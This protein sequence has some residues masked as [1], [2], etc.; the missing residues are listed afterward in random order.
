[1]KRERLWWVRLGWIP[2]ASAAIVLLHGLSLAQIP[3]AVGSESGPGQV[4][5]GTSG[6]VP[7]TLRD[8]YLIVVEGRIGARRGPR[9]STLAT[10]PRTGELANGDSGHRALPRA[11]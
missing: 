10:S 8:G 1:M 11:L 3:E 5:V 6:V 4:G 9:G 2:R 7:F